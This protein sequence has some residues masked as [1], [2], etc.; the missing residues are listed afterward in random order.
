[1]YEMSHTV[2]NYSS[3]FN[4]SYREYRMYVVL[5]IYIHNN[6]NNNKK[7]KNLYSYSKYT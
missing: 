1:M 7:K 5:L 2:F 4:T 6:N 3:A